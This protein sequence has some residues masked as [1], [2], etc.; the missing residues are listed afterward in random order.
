MPTRTHDGVKKRCGCAR[1]LWPKCPHPWHFSFHHGGREHRYSLDQVARARN[2]RP[3]TTKAAA[4]DWRDRLRSEIREGKTPE[5][6]APAAA[7]AL[8]VGDVA[9]RYLTDFVGK[10]ETEGKVDWTGRH[11]RPASALQADYAIRIARACDVPA[12][13]GTVRFEAKPIT[14]VTKADL[15]AIR[16][17][18][19]PRGVVGCNRLLARLRHFF[20]WAIGEGFTE[21]NPFK[22]HGVSVVKLETGAEVPRTRRLEPGEEEALLAAA[23][24]LLRALIVAAL[25]TG[26]RV[27]E[28]LS[29]QWWQ[30]RRDETGDAR[31]I[32]L[33]AAKTKTNTTR[34]LPIGP[35]L[36][37]EL[38]MRRHAPDGTEHP[39]TAYVF[40]NECGER[41]A[42]VKKAWEIAVLRAHGVTP[43]WV[44]GKPGQLA[45][46][47]RNA[48]KR[49]DLHFH[50]LRRQFACT[51]LESSADLHDVR[52]FLGHANV[53]TT[54]RYLSSSPVRLARA[55]ARLEGDGDG[56]NAGDGRRFR[57][58]FAHGE[59]A[60][61]QPATKP[62]GN[63]LN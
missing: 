40:G 30:I 25:S 14:A 35:R 58:P 1:K 46:E 36:R 28:L 62:R 20:N 56:A 43:K 18:R 19:R 21:S 23:N 15:E 24:P 57:T 54:S 29:L 50:D 52:D 16:S 42:C 12:A 6:T 47:C 8:T 4:L 53:T 26:C 44:A 63:S 41:I 39:P 32:D 3:P 59:G 17:A 49:I 38:E 10:R 27:G 60:A 61:D 48:L 22:R 45:P 7:V 37:A 34:S 51:L 2:E 13:G 9:D 55:L 31:W 5:A 11:L 33:P